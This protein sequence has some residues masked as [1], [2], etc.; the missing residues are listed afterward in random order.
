LEEQA[1][2]GFTQEFAT[3]S[4]S[5]STICKEH[6]TQLNTIIMLA[7]NAVECLAR[8]QYRVS[9]FKSQKSPNFHP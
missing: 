2:S 4:H 5:I 8:Q 6:K 7:S 1:I 9:G 3:L